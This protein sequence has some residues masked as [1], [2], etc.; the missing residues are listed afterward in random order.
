MTRDRY[1]AASIACARAAGLVGGLR[2]IAE[3][4]GCALSLRSLDQLRN[5][6]AALERLV[7]ADRDESR[8][9]DPVDPAEWGEGQWSS[10]RLPFGRE[11]AA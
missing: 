9:T 5:E 8:R 7:E 3:H 6:L 2:G 1:L 4:R 10:P 11:E